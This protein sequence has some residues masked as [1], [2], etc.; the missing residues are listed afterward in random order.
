M[1]GTALSDLSALELRRLIGQREISP[2]ELLDA[3]LAR[4]ETINP[5]VNAVVALD[6]ERAR[7]E[8]KAAEEAA[9]RGEALGP[10]AGLVIGVKDLEETAG[11][12]T[13][14]GSRQFEHFVPAEDCGLVARLRAAG[15]IVLAKTN[16][17]EFGAGANT[18]NPVYGPTGNPF[19]PALSCAG[20][21]GGSAVA[22]ATGMLPLATG[23]DTGGSLRNPAAFC[24]IVGFRPTPG[25]VPSEKRSSGWS[26]LPV[27]GPMARSVPDLALFLSAMAAEDG[28]DPLSAPLAPPGF[29]PLAECD[30]A[31]LR[32]AVTEDFGFAPVSAEVRGLF[33]DRIQSIRRLFGSVV[34]ACPDMSGADEAFAV[35]RAEGMLARHLPTYRSRPHL[36]GPNLIANIEEGLG[37]TLADH[38]RA[39]AAQTAIARRFHAFF[40]EVDLILSPAMAL[41]PMPWTVLAPMEIDGVGLRS[42]YHWL[43]L[44][45]GVTLAAH[46]ALVLPCG[47]DS[48]GLPFGLQVVGPRRGDAALLSAAAA[49]ERALATTPGCGRPLPDLSALAR[50]PPI[51]ERPGADMLAYVGRA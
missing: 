42:Y 3:C 34:E 4:I 43:A 20:S 17:P 36:L 10:L 24:G 18:V 48:R 5:A 11:L 51:G 27:L 9:R 14:Y 8:A 13:T 19:D 22:L 23:S 12:R 31:S 1:N 49:L 29:F 26:P 39:H 41:Q 46:P 6:T 21:S 15:A 2:V 28:R 30:L 44:A 16:T 37:Y 32:V 35:L 33:R 50:M 45:Y 47:V 38:A 25:L 7:V 40:D